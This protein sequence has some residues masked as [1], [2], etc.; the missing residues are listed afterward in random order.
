VSI[1]SDIELVGLIGLT[2]LLVIVL[3]R[4]SQRQDD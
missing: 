2:S 4:W 3:D 1:L